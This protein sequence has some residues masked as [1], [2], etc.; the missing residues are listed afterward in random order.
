MEIWP[1]VICLS[2]KKSYQNKPSM[3]MAAGEFGIDKG[4]VCD[5]MALYK[6]NSQSFKNCNNKP[7][8]HYHLKSEVSKIKFTE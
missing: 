7:S 4:E 3:R 8:I 1:T 6:H 2:T 5:A